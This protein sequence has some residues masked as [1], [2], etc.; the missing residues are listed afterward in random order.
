M[1][2]HLCRILF[3]F[4]LIENRLSESGTWEEIFDQNV[5]SLALMD[6]IILCQRMK[7]V[8]QKKEAEVNK[9]QGQRKSKKTKEVIDRINI[10]SSLFPLSLS[11]SFSFSFLFFSFFR[12]AQIKNYTAYWLEYLPPIKLL[13]KAPNT[14]FEYWQRSVCVR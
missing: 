3:Y 8:Q 10:F 4:K 11:S 13:Q 12:M 14:R 9:K 5:I 1:G 2:E 6:Q 7:L